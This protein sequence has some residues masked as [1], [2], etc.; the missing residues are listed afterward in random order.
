MNSAKLAPLLLIVAMVVMAVWYAF[1]QGL[2]SL[3]FVYQLARL[4]LGSLGLS[5]P[6]G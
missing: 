6:G 5:L 2:Y 4:A 3:I 1:P